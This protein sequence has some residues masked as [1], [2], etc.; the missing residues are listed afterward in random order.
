[1]KPRVP[2]PTLRYRLVFIEPFRFGLYTGISVLFVY[3]LWI[4]A[5]H[6]GYTPWTPFAKD[7]G[8]HLLVGA[9][10]ALFAGILLGVLSATFFDIVAPRV[11]GIPFHLVESVEDTGHLAHCPDCGADV[12]RGASFCPA[13][14]HDFDPPAPDGTPPEGRP[15]A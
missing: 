15:R 12:L 14:D 3:L 8:Y 7:L 11:G 4:A 1:M 10:A 9:P 5:S 2:Q 6:A 13:C